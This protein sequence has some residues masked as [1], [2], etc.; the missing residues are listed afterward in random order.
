MSGATSDDDSLT[1][2]YNNFDYYKAEVDYRREQMLRDREP[3]RIW[4][5]S[6]KAVTAPA[7]RKG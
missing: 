7:N 1:M 3:I 4:R 2:N 6:R 5:R